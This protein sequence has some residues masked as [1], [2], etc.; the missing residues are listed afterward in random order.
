MGECVVIILM[1]L[2]VVCEH[3]IFDIIILPPFRMVVEVVLGRMFCRC[4]C[5]IVATTILVWWLRW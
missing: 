5:C 2:S 3:D 4:I 1:G